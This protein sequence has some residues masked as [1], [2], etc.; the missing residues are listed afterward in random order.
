MKT[1]KMRR[2]QL[3]ISA[4]RLVHVLAWFLPVVKGGG[5]FPNAL[6]GWQ[7]FRLAACAVWPI[8]DVSF[9]DEWYIAVLSTISAGTTVLFVLC[10]ALVVARGS[11][12]LRRVSAWIAALSFVVNSHWFLLFG[13]DRKELRI[14]Y[15]LWSSFLLVALGLFDLSRRHSDDLTSQ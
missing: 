2:P 8:H 7:A 11:R 9:D 5:T 3:L 1:P 4:A 15:F 13:S 6:P 12:A 10:S 14:G